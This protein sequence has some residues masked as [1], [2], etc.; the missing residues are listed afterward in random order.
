MKLSRLASVDHPLALQFQRAFESLT[1]GL[2]WDSARPYRGTVRNFL[3]YL[4]DDHPAVCSLIA[5]PRP[6]HSWLVQPFAFT[7]SAI[8]DC[9]LHLSPHASAVHS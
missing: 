3:I 1:A 6:A 8:G 4:G 9:R 2:Q 7:D 5:A